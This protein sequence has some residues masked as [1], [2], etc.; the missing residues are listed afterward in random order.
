MEGVLS[1]LID[2]LRSCHVGPAGCDYLPDQSR[3]PLQRHQEALLC[4]V[5]RAVAGHQRHHDL[6]ETQASQCRPEGGAAD[7]LQARW[8]A[9]ECGDSIGEF[10][11]IVAM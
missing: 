10:C 1:R 6:K 8:R 4:G 5:P 3:W 7:Q 9:V 11:Q 2:R